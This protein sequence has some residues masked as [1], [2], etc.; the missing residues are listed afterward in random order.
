MLQPVKR[1]DTQVAGSF[2]GAQHFRLHEELDAQPLLGHG[3]LR[4]SIMGAQQC[5]LGAIRVPF[6]SISGPTRQAAEQLT[7]GKHYET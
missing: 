1:G 4:A 6:V 2:E 7:G 5:C 3:L